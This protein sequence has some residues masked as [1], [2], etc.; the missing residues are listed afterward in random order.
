M[1]RRLTKEE[2]YTLHEAFETAWM[3]DDADT[4]EDIWK[5]LND[6]LDAA[7]EDLNEFKRHYRDSMV[8]RDEVI[9]DLTKEV[10][11]WRDLARLRG[12]IIGEKN[13]EIERLENAVEFER[14]A[15][16]VHEERNAVLRIEAERSV[17]AV[18]YWSKESERLRAALDTIA[19]RCVTFAEMKR[20]A[21]TAIYEGD[22]DA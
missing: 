18:E 3:V 4:L 11:M 17:A 14:N 13:D 6:D 9:A 5:R 20:Y 8:E 12:E 21:R 22:G 19:N 16:D 2:R 7:D 1:E 15:C 10:E